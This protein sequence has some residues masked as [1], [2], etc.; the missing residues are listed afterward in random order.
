MP[1]RGASKGWRNGRDRETERY[2]HNEERKN[3]RLEGS[4]KQLDVS[5]W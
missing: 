3:W 2:G 4:E 5:S 1:L